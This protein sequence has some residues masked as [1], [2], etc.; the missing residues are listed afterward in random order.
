MRK[1]R[2]SHEKPIVKDIYKNISAN[3]S[4]EKLLHTKYK[5]RISFRKRNPYKNDKSD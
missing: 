4:A 3:L 2:R 1:Y 5:R